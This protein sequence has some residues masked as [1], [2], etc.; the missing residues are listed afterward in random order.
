MCLIPTHVPAV[1]VTRGSLPKESWA[2]GETSPD[3]GPGEGLVARGWT[4]QA[5]LDLSLTPMPSSLELCRGPPEWGRCLKHG[6]D[7]PWELRSAASP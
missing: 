6:Q 5:G 4:S 1:R 7:G 3:A 2:L